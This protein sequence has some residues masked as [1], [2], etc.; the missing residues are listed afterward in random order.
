MLDRDTT[1]AMLRTRARRRVPGST[2]SVAG[3]DASSP[4]PVTPNCSTGYISQTKES[5]SRWAVMVVPRRMSKEGP[6]SFTVGYSPVL[7]F[8]GLLA[9]FGWR[10]VLIAFFIAS[11]ALPSKN[12]L[13]NRSVEIHPLD[14][15]TA[16]RIANVPRCMADFPA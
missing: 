8:A 4:T 7:P 15:Q 3:V 11:S 14:K 16:I 10:S 2:L 5:V 9:A 1:D 13:S 12:N 6:A